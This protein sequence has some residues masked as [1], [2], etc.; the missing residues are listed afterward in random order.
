MHL[1]GFLLWNTHEQVVAV[2]GSVAPSVSEQKAYDALNTKQKEEKIRSLF[3]VVKGQCNL[4]V[5]AENGSI[6]EIVKRAPSI[7]V[8]LNDTV[9]EH[10]RARDS[11]F[12]KCFFL[13]FKSFYLMKAAGMTPKL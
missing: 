4:A 10:L 1:C 9:R 2:G 6:E 8:F 13:E 7:R 11:G 3:S 12:G 5:R